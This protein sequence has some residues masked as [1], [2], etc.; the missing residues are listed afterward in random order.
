MHN[1]L[2]LGQTINNIIYLMPLH[3]H[4]LLTYARSCAASIVYQEQHPD[5]M[6]QNAQDFLRPIALPLRKSI[7][8]RS[9]RLRPPKALSYCSLVAMTFLSM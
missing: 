2:L 3:K 7:H 8:S 1:Q 6:T 9:Q 4:L 5:H